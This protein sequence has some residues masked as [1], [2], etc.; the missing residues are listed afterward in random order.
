MVALGEIAGA[1]AP[2]GPVNL[3]TVR[4]PL[5]LPPAIALTIRTTAELEKVLDSRGFALDG[6]ASGRS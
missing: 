5:S 3:I 2:S 6:V 4:T 1:S